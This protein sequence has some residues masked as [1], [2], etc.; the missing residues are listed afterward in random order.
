MHV[1]YMKKDILINNFRNN[2]RFGEQRC[3]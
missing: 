3:H 1:G 2:L